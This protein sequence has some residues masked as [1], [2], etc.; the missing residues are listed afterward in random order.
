MKCATAPQNGTQAHDLS[1][2][3]ELGRPAQSALPRFGTAVEPFGRQQKN[4]K[5]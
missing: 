4:T 3:L 2:E 5:V 1:R